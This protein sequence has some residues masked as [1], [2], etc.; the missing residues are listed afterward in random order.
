MTKTY[1]P[2]I[3]FLRQI[4]DYNPETGVLT[5]KVRREDSFFIREGRTPSHISNAWNAANSGKTALSSMAKNKYLRGAINGSTFYAHR[6]AWA[7]HHGHWPEHDIDHING[8]RNDNRIENLRSVSR[9]NNMQNREMSSNNTS[10][11]MGV[12]YSRRHKLWCAKIGDHHIGWFSD[13]DSAV[14]ARKDAESK[15]EYHANHGRKP[16]EAISR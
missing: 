15:L 12:S 1:I 16:V 3:E 6:V 10:G 4:L 13:K 7:L 9:K 8:V 11:F 2:S 5:W 14:E